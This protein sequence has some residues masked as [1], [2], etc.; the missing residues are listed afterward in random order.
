MNPI[1]K[2][3]DHGSFPPMAEVRKTLKI[4]WYRCPIE[5]PVLA[6]LV[7]RSDVKGLLQAG[8]HL[9]VWAITAVLCWYFY[10]VQSWWLF[11]AL[12]FV[13]GTVASF[14]TSPH[15]ELCH[16]TVFE[17][18]WLNEFFLRIYSLLGWQNFRV[19]RF[20]HN[21]HHRYTLFL[22]GDREEILPVTPSL[23]VLYLLQL[24]T[25][26]IF[27]GYQSRGV[28]PAVTGFIKIALNRF[29]NPFNSWGEELYQ[30][31]DEQRRKA[32]NWARTV[33]FFHALVIA[34]SIL[35]GQPELALIISGAPFI[36]NWHRY[37]VG[38]TMHCRLISNVAD[39]RK[40]ARSIVLD[41]VS[42]FLYWHMNWHLEHHM[43]AA[44]PC[45]NLKKLHA[46]VAGDMPT[47]RTLSGAWREMRETWR[48]QQT[49]PEYAYDT[50]V[51][52]AAQVAGGPVD[53][54]AESV[55]DLVNQ[56]F[57][58]RVPAG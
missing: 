9:A 35:A 45:Y 24:F 48:R 43:F 5:K 54:N 57:A 39:F 12:L 2:S 49:D 56:E 20:S 58:R 46:A 6:K 50:P 51:P 13:H 26:N 37:F 27:G 30:G 22:Q 10:S 40:C 21:Y 1:S 19:Y 3:I 52:S 7:V 25:F 53:P 29:D 36:A 32:V 44:V 28:L 38:V 42:E 16:R 17:T 33:L 47:P 41:P 11:F 18:R 34:G 15:H 4:D 55:G 8:G 14:F 23:R 31:H